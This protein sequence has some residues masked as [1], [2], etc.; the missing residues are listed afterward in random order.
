ML[1]TCSLFITTGCDHYRKT[2]DN[3][4]VPEPF[5]PGMV[6]CPECCGDGILDENGGKECRECDGFGKMYEY[7]PNKLGEYHHDF[8]RGYE[9]RFDGKSKKDCPYLLP[10]RKEKWLEGWSV[11]DEK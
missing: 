10:F 8:I 2:I 9:D 1:I 11:A 3:L 5:V 7:E 6:D 4:I